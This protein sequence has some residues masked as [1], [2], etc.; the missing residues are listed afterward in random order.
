MTDAEALAA[1]QHTKISPLGAPT[2]GPAPNAAPGTPTT[3]VKV[4]EMFEGKFA[5]DMLD[6]LL[7]ALLVVVLRMMKL[8]VRK[9]E[10]Q[11][12]ESE[13]KT[14]APVLQNCLNTLNLDF[15]NPWVALSVTAGIIYGSKVLE[16]GAVGWLDKKAMEPIKEKAKQ[17]A[18]ENS[19]KDDISVN[20]TNISGSESGTKETLVKSEKELK[21][22][23]NPIWTDEQI[24]AEMKRLRRGRE[25]AIDSL[26]KLWRKQQKIQ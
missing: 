21:T 12:T 6:A 26:N 3:T 7:P 11:L 1:G 8:T 14:L 24:R 5:V 23:A 9:S 25:G 13:K 19:I 16:K 20:K 15:N 10:M 17:N 18:K 22:M 2:G 4:G